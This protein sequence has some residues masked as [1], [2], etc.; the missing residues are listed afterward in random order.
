MLDQCLVDANRKRGGAAWVV[1][2]AL[3][4]N[5]LELKDSMGPQIAEDPQNAS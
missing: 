3:L 2:L 4:I 1:G 5:L